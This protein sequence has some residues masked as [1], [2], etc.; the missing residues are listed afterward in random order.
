M[1]ISKGC[2]SARWLQTHLY[3]RTEKTFTRNPQERKETSAAGI[4][5]FIAVALWIIC[6]VE[7]HLHA[8]AQPSSVQQL[9]LESVGAGLMAGDFLCTVWK[10]S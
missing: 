4:T 9:S 2:L 6:C 5:L 3:F 8:K 10:P 7:R 1:Q